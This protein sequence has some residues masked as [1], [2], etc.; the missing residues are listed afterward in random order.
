MKKIIL[1]ILA[2]G[3]IEATEI[4]IRAAY[5]A[6]QDDRMRD[7]YSNG[8]TEYEV[9][10]STKLDCLS[11]C[12]PSFDAFINFATYQKEGT[13]TCTLQKDHT[14][15]RNSALNVGIK[16]YLDILCLDFHPYLG[17]GVG[18]A[19]VRFH[20]KSHHVKEHINEWG[21]ALLLKSG[22]KY[23][24]MCNFFA[25]LFLDYSYQWFS[26]HKRHCAEVHDVNP[27]G[28]MVGL[29]AGFEF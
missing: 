27:G 26:F 5:F 7:I 6:P 24:I 29:G 2:I 22:I 16:R 15:V 10:V 4:E 14:T 28:V 3:S 25:D 21:G 13:S 9:E 17:L 20:D 19:N 12:A 8:F 23:N 1:F 18:V 11:P